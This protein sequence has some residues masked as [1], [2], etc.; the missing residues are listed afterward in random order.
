MNI[1]R[2]IKK[3]INVFKSPILNTGYLRITVI[4]FSNFL[5]M[6]FI[7]MSYDYC[8]LKHIHFDRRKPKT[9]TLT[10]I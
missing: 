3:V 7:Y 5:F 2:L 9:R 1:K 8:W 6:T 10:C 4:I